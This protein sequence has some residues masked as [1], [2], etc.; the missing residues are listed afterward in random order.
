MGKLLRAELYQLVRKKD[1]YL[2]LLV[3]GVLFYYFYSGLGNVKSIRAINDAMHVPGGIGRLVLI[4][5]R[6]ANEFS[7]TEE[8]IR[9]YIPWAVGE[10]FSEVNPVAL[11][12]VF[13]STYMIGTS[14]YRRTL[15][16]TIMQGYTR[17]QVFLSKV[18]IYYMTS[19]VIILFFL[20][21]FLFYT[22]GYLWI[23][24]L[25]VK[26]ILLMFTAWIYLEIAIMSI[27]L[28]I[29]FICKDI[30]KTTLCSFLFF[31]LLV[32]I[33]QIGLHR[34]LFS[35][36]P[37]FVAVDPAIWRNEILLP[38][39]QWRFSFSVMPAMLIIGSI[40]ISY[41]LFRKAELK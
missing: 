33:N 32:F 18:L 16:L 21:F 20:L 31:A 14:F 4:M 12:S 34:T 36:Y 39:T 9:A 10:I 5:G 41:F 17:K 19:S 24:V 28:L 22:F 6:N 30:L 35:F 26:H 11:I 25:S 7:S 29:P 38:I 1:F 40:L 3:M 23:T 37:L 15:N 8:V 13:Y 2:M 27:P